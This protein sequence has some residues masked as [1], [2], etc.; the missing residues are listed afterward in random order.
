M[1]NAYLNDEVTLNSRNK[2]I[3]C[4]DKF[5]CKRMTC[6]VCMRIRR[7]YFVENGVKFA[8]VN[9]LDTHLIVSWHWSSIVKMDNYH[10]EQ[11]Q[12]LPL[13]VRTGI[14]SKKM[15][16]VKAKPYIRV[17]AI[18]KKG[19]PHIHFILSEA[20]AN[21]V[22]KICDKRWGKKVETNH[23]RIHDVQQLLGY[24]FD[25]NFLPTVNRLDRIKG[26]RLITA[27][28]PMRCGFP[29]RPTKKIQVQRIAAQ[30]LEANTNTNGNGKES[31]LL[32][33][34]VY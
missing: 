34:V 5:R 1:T 30:G 16:G 20:V 19:C 8:S 11:D 23:I 3:R 2:K 25:Q 12:W 26:I 4:S 27:S 28:R 18:G 33:G 14:L 15:S 9:A 32:N 10:V 29:T 6:E 13:V 22:R 24:F 17:L 31:C 7:R 21:K